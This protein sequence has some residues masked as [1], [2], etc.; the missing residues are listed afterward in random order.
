MLRSLRSTVVNLGV[1][2]PAALFTGLGPIL[3][4]LILGGTS[5][6]WLDGFLNLGASQVPVFLL[7]TAGLSAFS[8]T[9]THAASLLS[10]MA[11]GVGLGTLVA[12]VGVGMAAAIGFATL[13]FLLRAKAVE[14]LSHHP[15]A[16]AIHRELDQGHDLRTIGLLALIRLSPVMPFAATNLL[17]STTGIRILP[18]LAGSMVGLAPRIFAVVWIGSSLTELDLS[19]AADQ[20]VL[21]LGIVATFAVLWILRKVSRRGLAQ[22]EG[23]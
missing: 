16:E 11:F 10:G 9:P 20:R 18:F 15:R 3:G 17:M 12:L 6:Y 14:A 5:P 8:L 21:I 2:G 7:L 19:Q 4:A 23:A 22:L 1:L 13:R